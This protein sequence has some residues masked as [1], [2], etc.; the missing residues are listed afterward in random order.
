MLNPDSS[1]FRAACSI[2]KPDSGLRE[3]CRLPPST[4]RR[5]CLCRTATLILKVLRVQPPLAPEAVENF[6]RLPDALLERRARHFGEVLGEQTVVEVVGNRQWRGLC[7]DQ[8]PRPRE[9]SLGRGQGI[10]PPGHCAPQRV[11]TRAR[12]LSLRA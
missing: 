8:T 9:K 10:L 11:K 2:S 6:S 3:F 12:H 1:P 7:A 4:R 5:H